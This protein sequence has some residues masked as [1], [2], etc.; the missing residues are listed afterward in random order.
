MSFRRTR[1]SDRGMTL[2]EVMIAS[3]ILLVCLTGLGTL[4]GGAVNSSRTARMRDEAANLA[5]ERIET[6]RSLAYDQVGV[7]YANGLSGDPAGTILTP[8]TEGAFVVTTQCTW[9]RTAG[10]RAAY[11]QLTVSV[12]WQQP[13]PGHLDVTTMI[14]GKS[15]IVN[16][17]DLD[18]RLRYRED[19]S[20]VLNATVSI[21]D[22]NNSARSV[23]SDSS[24]EAFF[25]Q[26][27]IG[28][29]ALSVTPPAGCVVDTSTISNVSVSADAVSTII[30]Y[31]QR[32]AQSTIHVTDTDGA[33][34]AGATVTVRRADGAVLPVLTTNVN[35]DA[36][37]TALLYSD[38][39]A[40]VAKSG[41]SSASAP[42]TVNV[43]AAS[44]TV[45][46]GIS[47]L[48]GVGIHVRVFDTNGTQVPGATV[49]VRRN[50]SDTIL[51]QGT[52]GTNGEISFSG[53]DAGTYNTTVDKA[54]YVSQ[55][56]STSLYDGDIDT[57]DFHLVP[58]A[59]NGNMHITTYDKNGHA[60]S[61]RVIVSGS[62][63]YRNDLSSD[64]SGNLTLTGLVPGSYSVQ[65]YTKPASVAT[66]IVNAGQTANASVSQKR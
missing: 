15:D 7:R 51:Q 2:P 43:G 58:V 39:T 29:A 17:G 48:L 57:L 22:S 52:A 47:R 4:L 35:G 56:L 45:P 6:A 9:V 23:L 20:P 34:V 32:P 46:I 38:Y 54:S 37:F 60:T 49:T 16:S 11:K 31:I 28:A 13:T 10:G 14:Y 26:A 65:C 66:V 44:P 40:A 62:G 5:N 50:G 18:I 24:G 25:G 53:F 41:Y 30:V 33:P 64:S 21:V 63:Y 27:A 42:F 36:L 55:V 19:A 8:D 3:S 1:G 61:I 12:A 59:A